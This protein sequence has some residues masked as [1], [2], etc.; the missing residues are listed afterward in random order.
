MMFVVMMMIVMVMVGGC[1]CGMVFVCDGV[2]WGCVMVMDGGVL[3]V[4]G[5]RE[6]RAAGRGARGL[7]AGSCSFASLVICERL[8]YVVIEEEL[9]VKNVVEVCV[10]LLVGWRFLCVAV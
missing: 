2:M 6:A 10:R 8:N 7:S 3:L 9:W 1:G 5:G 4:G